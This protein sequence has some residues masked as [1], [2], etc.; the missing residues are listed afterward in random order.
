[1]VSTEDLEIVRAVPDKEAEESLALA[2]MQVVFWSG[3]I[4]ARAYKARAENSLNQDALVKRIA[5]LTGQIRDIKAAHDQEVYDMRSDIETAQD[6]WDE[7]KKRITELEAVLAT[8]DK[9]F[10]VGW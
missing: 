8:K 1:M 7:A 3:E 2:L 6:G 4:T 10:E 9:E 5:A